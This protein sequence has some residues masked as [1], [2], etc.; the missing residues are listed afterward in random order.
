MD[1]GERAGRF[2]FPIRDRDS[3]FTGAF[4]NFFSGNSDST[5]VIKTPVQSARANSNAER[6]VRT[7]AASAWITC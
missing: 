5:R 6:F 4:D 7:L 2:K 3:K 1:L